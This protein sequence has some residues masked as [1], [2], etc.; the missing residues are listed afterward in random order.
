MSFFKFKDHVFGDFS[1]NLL[2]FDVDKLSLDTV[3]YYFH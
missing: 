3:P 2:N 1:I